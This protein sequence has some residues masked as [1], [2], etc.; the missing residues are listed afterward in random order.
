MEEIA[1]QNSKDS[2]RRYIAANVEVNG[3]ANSN[4]ENKTTTTTKKIAPDDRVFLWSVGEILA[5]EV[6]IFFLCKKTKYFHTNGLIGIENRKYVFHSSRYSIRASAPART[7][8][9]L[10]K[11]SE[12]GSIQF[13]FVSFCCWF[14]FFISDNLNY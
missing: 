9:Q 1:Q 6:G 12:H 10:E 7:L 13:H 5:R 14:G 11:K 4:E 8:T 3:G 2:N